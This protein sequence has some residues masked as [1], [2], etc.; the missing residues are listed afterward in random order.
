MTY[1][2]R[3]HELLSMIDDLSVLLRG[4]T[5]PRSQ[6]EVTLAVGPLTVT[7]RCQDDESRPGEDE[8]TEPSIEASLV[9]DGGVVWSA[10]VD[11]ENVSVDHRPGETRA[12]IQELREQSPALASIVASAIARI[13]APLPKG[14]TTG[15]LR[16]M[17]LEIAGLLREGKQ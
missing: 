15:D 5:H 10:T 9:K 7:L 6:A 3:I 14:A 4:V 8:A 11:Q 12:V 2:D 1:L 16:D 13:E 17:I